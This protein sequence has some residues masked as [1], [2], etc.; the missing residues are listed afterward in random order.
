M[1]HPGIEALREAIN[2]F[3]ALDATIHGLRW[4]LA[5]ER[6]KRDDIMAALLGVKHRVMSDGLPCFCA[7][8]PDE[9]PESALVKEGHCNV[10]ETARKLFT[11]NKEEG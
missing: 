8:W 4:Q 9:D 6:R 11:P 7:I 10:C 5:M 3:D 1:S 2:A